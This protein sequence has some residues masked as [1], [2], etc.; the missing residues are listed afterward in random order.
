LEYLRLPFH[1]SRFP[2]SANIQPA[3]S[4]ASAASA[5]STASTV[6]TCDKKGNNS[7]KKRVAKKGQLERKQKSRR[8]RKNASVE[9]TQSMHSHIY[10]LIFAYLK[11][12]YCFCPCVLIAGVTGFHAQLADSNQN[13]ARNGRFFRGFHRAGA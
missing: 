2:G 1:A 8:N 7:K 9:V 4:A 13:V 11:L 12:K 6:S 5:T 3:A 10:N